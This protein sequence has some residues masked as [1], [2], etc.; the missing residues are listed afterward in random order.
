MHHITTPSTIKG[1]PY[2]AFYQHP[3]YRR[4]FSPDH[5]TIGIF[6]PLRF[7]EGDMNVLAG[8]AFVARTYT[9]IDWDTKAG[10]IRI[11]GYAHGSGPGSAW[12]SSIK[13]GDKC[14]VL[15]PRTSL[16][17]SRTVGTRVVLGDETSI[18]LAYALSHHSPDNRCACLLEVNSIIHVREVLVRLGLDHVEL[19]ERKGSDAHLDN[20]EH[21][22]RSLDAIETTFTLTGKAPSIQ[23]L[24]RALKASR[25]PSSR[26]MVKPYWAPGKTGLD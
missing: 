5:P 16:D 8:Q 9:P 15:G 14:D 2:A 11:L 6:L 17:I 19:F 1:S 25:V 26:L 3:G 20:I 24:H 21:R 4:M 22:M 18:G 13:P 23:R 7:Y 10:R 12:L